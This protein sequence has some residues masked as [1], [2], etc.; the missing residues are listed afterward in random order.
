MSKP[1]E[2]CQRRMP[3]A[4]ERTAYLEGDEPAPPGGWCWTPGSLG[5]SALANGRWESRALAA[6]E[7]VAAAE[8]L[9]RQSL[10]AVD[11]EWMSAQWF[12]DAHPVESAEY[13]ASDDISEAAWKEKHH[14]IG[15][16]IRVLLAGE[17]KE[18]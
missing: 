15:Q 4:G 16:A 10:P 14:E 7:R 13:M 1:C 17:G 18:H 6:E 2:K 11:I 5:C 9:L 12:E 3:D 8:G